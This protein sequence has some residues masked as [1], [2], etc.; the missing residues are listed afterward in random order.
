MVFRLAPVPFQFLTD[1]FDADLN[2]RLATSVNDVKSR[3]TDKVKV[4]EKQLREER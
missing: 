2:D 1:I 4:K 3:A